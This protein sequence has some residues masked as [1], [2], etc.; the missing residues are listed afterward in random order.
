[1]SI[2]EA[3]PRY[4]YRVTPQLS[5]NQMAEY[6]GSSTSSTRR[7]S[8]I[9]EARFPKTSQVAQYD[10]AREGLVNFL[11]DGTRSYKHLADATDYLEKREKK[12]DVSDWVRRDSR[13]SLE[14]IEAFQRSYNKLAIHKLDCRPVHGRQPHLDMWPTRISVAMNF[15]VHKPVPKGKDQ[16]GGAI[17]LFSKGESSTKNRI[18]RSK[19][20]AGLIYTHCNRFMTALGVPDPTLCFAIDVFSGVAHT[21]QGTFTRKLRNVGDACD[22]IAARW[23]TIPP[24][25]DYDGPDP[26]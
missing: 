17:L 22:E 10:K 16:I 23:K 20:I 25:A 21:P 9:R 14:A 1:M 13:G 2:P 15:T 19:T 11:T 3:G 12:P 7:T 5:A 26:G 6:L 18:E 24:P 4:T 8:I